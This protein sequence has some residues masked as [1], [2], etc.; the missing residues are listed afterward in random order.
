MLPQL[1]ETKTKTTIPWGMPIYFPLSQEWEEGNHLWHWESADCVLKPFHYPLGL[2][3]A[4]SFSSWVH[5]E[6]F[7]SFCLFVL[8]CFDT[9][10]LPVSR[11]E[12]SGAT[13]AHCNICLLGSSDSPAS[14]S[15]VA[16]TT[17]ACHHAQLIFLFLVDTGLHHVGQDGR[18]LDLVICPPWPPIVLGLQE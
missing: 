12:C 15:Q 10:S 2:Y 16:G 3:E 4:K 7:W 5:R 6:G 8:F 1:S 18:S 13:L 17:G 9:K 14:A 11:L